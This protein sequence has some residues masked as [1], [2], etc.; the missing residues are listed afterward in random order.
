MTRT[1]VDYGIDLG[2]T[3]SSMAVWEGT[4][5]KVFKN[6]EQSE[7]TPSAVRIDKGGGLIVGRAAKDYL[8]HDPENIACEFK[9]RMGTAIQWVFARSG[10]RMKPEELSAEVLKSLRNDGR[11]ANGEDVRAAV[12]TVPAAFELPQCAATKKAGE[13]AGY[14]F[15]PLLQEPV[16]AALAYGFQSQSDKVFW[17]VYDL[18]GGTFD[19][20][21]IHLRDGSFQV[22]NH[23][24]DNDLGGKRIDW[25]IVEQLLIP[26]ISRERRLTDFRRGNKAWIGAM[27]KLKQAAEESK[28]RL[29]TSETAE[30]SCEFLCKDDRGEAVEF[31]YV[32][33]RS[34][35]ARV[36]EPYIVQTINIC[37]KV[38]AEKR[39]GAGDVEKVILVGGPTLAPYFREM[40]ADRSRGLGIEL[41]YRIDPITVVARG[42]A[43]FAGTQ[44]IEGVAP[45]PITTGQYALELD[46]KPV[47]AETDPL[48]AGKVVASEGRSLT[49]FTIEFI[50]E[51][52]R[53]PWKTG[54]LPL[55]RTGTFMA[56]LNAETGQPNTFLIKLFDDAGTQHETIP[57]RLVYTVGTV[58]DNPPLTHSV[59]IALANNEP[60][61]YVR[62]GTPLPVTKHGVVHTTIDV[63]PGQTD[64]LIRIPVIEGENDRY[65]DRNQEVGLLLI[66]ADGIT[67]TVPAGSEIELTI[68][69]DSSRLVRTR[70]YV[71]LLDAEFEKVINLEKVEPDPDHLRTEFEREQ[72]RLEKI[73]VQTQVSR[74]AQALAAVRRI[75]EEGMESQIN[76]ALAA[77]EG[78]REVA[79]TCQSR[80]LALKVAIDQVADVLEWPRL[81]SEAESRVQSLREIVWKAGTSAE[82]QIAQSLERE[83]G[84]MIRAQDVDGLRRKVIEM[85]RLI[86][87]VLWRQPGY[88]IDFLH[89]LEQRRTSMYDQSQADILFAQAYRALKNND[90]TRLQEALFRLHSL[91][92]VEQQV[93]GLGSTVH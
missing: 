23:G 39:L 2:T 78:E 75:D 63:H 21:V 49:G 22:V 19:A 24:G 89:H 27:A 42:A 20:A 1:T 11:R 69:I 66:P 45:P 64:R 44:R 9:L 53:P 84:D 86:N 57:D 46:Y 80:L 60:A 41:E 33:H 74:D 43:I 14:Q 17:L 90:F 5:V 32:L 88:L 79:F 93:R 62:K 81:V 35:V 34:D 65:A 54:R 12:I 13:M 6:A 70:A 92:P 48:I 15:S 16:A 59:G 82:K 52:A 28:I 37:K 83:T 87:G 10:R 38:L 8:E 73:R 58:V 18:G 77:S 25:D 91:F 3:N 51:G 85:N 40:V 71:P 26:A 50:N 7:S 72:E 29:S 47:G 68:E 30:I 76:S 31:E 56:T 4:E 55:S 67:R 61:F 36:A